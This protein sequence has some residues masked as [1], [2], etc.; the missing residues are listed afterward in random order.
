MSIG[1]NVVIGKGVHV[2]DSI[3]LDGV[4]IKDFSCVLY[5]I[6]GWGSKI[7]SWCRVEGTPAYADSASMSMA[8]NLSDVGGN[9]S[10][11]PTTDLMLP[12]GVKN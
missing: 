3:I 2:K 9:V 12:N 1:K 4:Q 5:S 7:G 10:S 11:M 6:V 8:A